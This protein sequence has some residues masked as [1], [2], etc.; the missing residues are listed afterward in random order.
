MFSSSELSSYLKSKYVIHE[1]FLNFLLGMF[2][3][4]PKLQH[5]IKEM[6]LLLNL[7]Q[8]MKL[9]FL[10]L[11]AKDKNI[12]FI[13]LVQVMAG[14]SKQH[15]GIIPMLINTNLNFWTSLM[16]LLQ[17]L[18]EPWLFPKSSKHSMSPVTVLSSKFH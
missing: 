11:E 3:T 5:S 2:H 10:I 4:M 9:R 7:S 18:L 8:T 6:S 15:V 14:F 12:L 17:N 16:P 1:K 13:M